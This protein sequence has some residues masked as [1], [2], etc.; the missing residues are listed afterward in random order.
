[1]P[2]E[3]VGVHGARF[4]EQ[5]DAGGD[6]QDKHS[7]AEAAGTQQG[8]PRFPTCPSTSMKGFGSSKLKLILLPPPCPPGEPEAPARPMEK[9]EDHALISQEMLPT[10]FHKP[11]A[12]AA[13]PSSSTGSPA[14]H[15]SRARQGGGNKCH[16]QQE[17]CPITHTIT[18]TMTQFLRPAVIYI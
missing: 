10:L 17:I 9:G 12:Q 3:A 16:P 2:G 1:M 7:P 5:M 14:L 13:H 18:L 11:G 15:M 4:G 6:K 8:S